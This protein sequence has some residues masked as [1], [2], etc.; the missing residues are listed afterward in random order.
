MRSEDPPKRAQRQ[1]VLTARG[2]GC[3]TDCQ[4]LHREWRDDTSRG[5]I[6]VGARRPLDG[7]AIP[8]LPSR[9]GCHEDAP[10][11][12]L[13]VLALRRACTFLSSK[14]SVLTTMKTSSGK[15]RRVL[16][17]GIIGCGY[18]AE[19]LHLPA[20]RSVPS[21]CPMAIADSDPER[22]ALVGDRFA[23]Q[24]RY[25][26]P[27]ALLRDTEIDAVAVCVPP[28]AHAEI[29][30]AVLDAGR[31]L[32]VEK[33][34]C[35]D[36]DDADRLVER[37][38]C[39]PV[40]A[41]VGFNL[42]FHRHVRAARRALEEGLIGPAELVRTTWSGGLRE[43]IGQPEWRRR[44]DL[45]G[46]VLN[47][48]AVHHLDLWR[49]LL[50]SEV[51]EVFASSRSEGRHDTKAT[52]TARL[53]IGALAVSGFC[54]GGAETHEIEVCGGRGRLVASL[55]RFDGLDL[56]PA[57]TFPD[58][59]GHRVWG[60]LRT[61]RALPGAVPV[62]LRGGDFLES[63]RAEWRHFAESALLG[64][65]VES[66]LDDGRRALELVLATIHSAVTNRPV[67]V[68]GAPRRM[69]EVGCAGGQ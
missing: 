55:Y 31:H 63:Y 43:Q 67:A 69:A 33:P 5:S 65:P 10:I 30:L 29:A 24:R 44:R 25:L 8:V 17:V 64:A 11:R 21:V 49:F 58:G 52:I 7:P 13:L 3:P 6:L 14:V 16:R 4:R 20:L 61:A 12:N 56:V 27:E 15:R 9:P 50:G 19:R 37:A 2:V 46:G 22:L 60:L 57:S 48:L 42:R 38:R 68:G 51:A 41:M 34:L 1:V 23:I 26:D 54:Q 35:L 47:E 39:A 62:A 45:G 32:L 40:A 59:F 18:A 53:Q 28:R 36:L 66:T